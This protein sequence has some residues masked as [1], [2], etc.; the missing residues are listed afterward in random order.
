M[1]P[2]ARACLAAAI[3]LSLLWP[4]HPSVLA[5]NPVFREGVDLV[6]LD[7]IVLDRQRRPVTGL[8]AADFTIL[9]DG[10]SREIQAFS[11]VT[12]PPPTPV[13]GAAWTRETG[14]DVVTNAIADEGRVVVVLLD[15]SIP[16]GAPTVW[17]RKIAHAAVDALGPN[18]L[19]AVIHGS[20]FGGNGREQNLTANRSRLR[21]AIDAPFMGGGDLAESGACLCGLCALTNIEEIVRE[22]EGLSGRHKA[23][24]FIGSDITI[25][26]RSLQMNP[27]HICEGRADLP[28]ERLLQTLDRANVTLHTLDPLGLDT[29]QA[30]ADPT[31]RRR[32]RAAELQRQGDIAV[33]PDYT[34]GRTVLNTNEPESFVPA[35]FA[36]SQSYYL[37]GFERPRDGR[38]GQRRTIRVRVN[39]DGVTV[40]SR[41]GYYVPPETVEEIV[42]TTT[43]AQETLGGLL[44]KTD[45]PLSLALTPAFL[46]G[47]A[48][49]VNVL[50]GVD[51]HDGAEARAF[52][53]T[54]GVFDHRARHVRTDRV[55]AEVA[56]SPTGASRDPVTVAWPVTLDAGQYEVRVGVE[57]LSDRR[58]GSVYG[59]VDIEEEREFAMAGVDVVAVTN[60]SGGEPPATTRRTFARADTVIARTQVLRRRAQDGDVRLRLTLTDATDRIVRESHHEVTEFGSDGVKTVA[61]PLPVSGLMSGR[62]LLVLEGRQGERAVRRAVPFAVGE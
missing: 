4:P 37:L 22:L 46:P 14:P 21:T 29:L 27:K 28:R 24:L 10:T 57:D 31:A 62:Y 58:T 15:Q 6:R 12:L 51:E 16:V 5:Q 59:Y 49:V 8:T 30:Q 20:P 44:P 43:P 52:E 33:F 9:E 13:T 35:I 3:A 25:D 7:V 55:T 54:I 32:S 53:V 36:E 48:Q 26:D 19:A 56:A 50:V 34:G 11:A 18:D 47:A 17:S 60:P 23:I 61:V 2:A 42:D 38:P 45:I 40:R 1:T 41:T 39:R